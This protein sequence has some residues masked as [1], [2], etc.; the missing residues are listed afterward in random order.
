[1][2]EDPQARFHRQARGEHGVPGARPRRACGRQAPASPMAHPGAVFP[3]L[4]R[5]VAL[6][7]LQGVR[8]TGCAHLLCV[9]LPLRPPCHRETMAHAGPWGSSLEPRAAPTLLA[10]GAPAQMK[11][12]PSGFCPLSGIRRQAALLA[13]RRGFGLWRDLPGTRSGYSA[14]SSRSARTAPALFLP[15]LP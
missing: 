11:A 12:G 2:S 15:R 8:P 14:R 13:E 6:R 4:R 5:D 10:L 1:M 3:R 7:W 9:C